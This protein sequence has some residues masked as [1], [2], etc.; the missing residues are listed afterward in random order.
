MVTN[1]IEIE[2]KYQGV[3]VKCFSGDFRGLFNF[4]IVSHI[5]QTVLKQMVSSPGTFSP[6]AA[7]TPRIWRDGHK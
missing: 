1:E 7:P 6:Y 3:V 5:V 2:I 4:I